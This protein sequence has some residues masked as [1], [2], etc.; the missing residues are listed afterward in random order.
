MPKQIKMKIGTLVF[1]RCYGE[2]WLDGTGII[3]GGETICPCCCRICEDNNFDRY[4]CAA[5]TTIDPSCHEIPNNC[6]LEDA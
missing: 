1:N 6:P 2:A 4:E 3:D 5:D